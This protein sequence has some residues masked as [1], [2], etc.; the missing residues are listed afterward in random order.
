MTIPTTYM[1]ALLLCILSMV[2]WGSWANTMKLAPKWRFELYYFDYA[3]GVMLAAIVICFT[4]GTYGSE[5]TFQ[6]N[7]TIIRLRPVG[8][9]LAAGVVFNLANMLLV[10]A[11]AVAGMAVAFPVGIG[12]ALVLGVVVSYFMRPQGNPSFL[13]LG[14]SIVLIAIGLAALAYKL[15]QDERNKRQPLAPAPETK[16]K[17][18]VRVSAWK[19]LVLSVVAGVLMGSFYP[20]I[21]MTRGYEIEMGPYAILIVFAAGVL[22]S[23]FLF[24]IFFITLPIQGKPVQVMAYF[25]GTVKQHLLGLLGG[26]VWC[27]G[28]AANLVASSVP[29]DVHVGPAVSY[30]LGQGAVMIS[31][32]WGLLVW[33]EFSDS[34]EKSRL[35]IWL[36]VPVFIVGLTLISVAPL[37]VRK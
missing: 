36:S 22:G 7:L 34:Q 17:Q 32:L 27:V 5:I 3:F 2:C 15:L 24:N 26:I 9:A 35:F 12:L 23:T 20:L 29:P 8:F 18:P 30:G 13:F 28:L 11:I 6:D 33:K 4:F 10:A 37:Y 16:R 25:K 19:G 21:E 1:A 14:M 31:T